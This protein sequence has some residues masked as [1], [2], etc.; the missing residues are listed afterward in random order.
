MA[1]GQTPAIEWQKFYGGTKDDDVISIRQTTDG[2]YI[3]IGD[4]DSNNGDLTSNNGKKDF[5]VVKSNH[6]GTIQWQ[7]SLGGSQDEEAHSI[8]QT[9]D[10]GYI[11]AG[12]TN[13]NDGDV[14]GNHG[15]TDAWIVKLNQ[16][17]DLV[18]QKRMGVPIAIPSVL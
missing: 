12:E 5:W 16:S 4:S 10:G 14:T 3:F 17:G 15:G 13:S 9:A 18:W 7:K 1:Y 8:R 11:I 2:G 6:L